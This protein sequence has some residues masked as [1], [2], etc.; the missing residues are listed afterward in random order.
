MYA[1]IHTHTPE[2]PLKSFIQVL[3]IIQVFAITFFCRP[4]KCGPRVIH[5]TNKNYIKYVEKYS[6]E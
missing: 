2:Q 5:K 3:I 4:N 6:I 1:E